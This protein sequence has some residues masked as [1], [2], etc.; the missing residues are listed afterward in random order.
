M[1]H[2]HRAKL[3]AVIAACSLLGACFVSDEALIPA[4]D[5]VLPI[6]HEITLC[7]DQPDDCIAMRVEADGY[8]TFADAA[9]DERGVARFFP[10]T[11]VDGRQIFLLEAYDQEDNVYSYLVAR[12]RGDGATGSAD[13]DLALISC[14]DLTEAQRSAFEAAGGSIGSGLVSECKSPDLETLSATVLDAY[15]AHF[16]DEDW[17]AEGGAN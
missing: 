8:T 1:F 9:E 17:W 16:T 15:G 11:Q 4:G 10:L 5:A 13:M 2:T 12:R 14:S 3:P 7:P 6:D